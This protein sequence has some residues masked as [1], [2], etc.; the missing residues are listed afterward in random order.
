M[1]TVIILYLFISY[2]KTTTD[3]GH[4]WC[5]GSFEVQDIFFQGESWWTAIF[6]PRQLNP[7]KNS[8]PTT[9]SIEAA[10]CWVGKTLYHNDNNL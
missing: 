7:K 10:C 5:H 8:R 6:K 3:M 1:L 4:V 2:T 9:N